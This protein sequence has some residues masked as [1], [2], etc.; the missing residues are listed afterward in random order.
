MSDSEAKHD[1]EKIRNAHKLLKEFT[2]ELKPVLR[3]Y[4]NRTLY[5]NVE[6]LEIREKPVAAEMKK[7]FVGGKGFDLKLLWDAVSGATRW[8]SPENEIF[9]ATGPICG[10]TNYPGS[11]KSLV[12]TISPMTGIPIDCNV[13]GYFGPYFKFS[14]FDALEIQGKAERDVLDLHRRQRGQGADHRSAAGGRGFAHR[15]P[16][17]STKCSPPTSATSSTSPWSRPAAAPSMPDRLP[18]LLLL[19][20]APQAA[21]LEA[22]GARRH[23]HRVPR[24]ED[25][26]PGG[27]VSPA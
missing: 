24:Q 18:Q 19:R 13:G 20:Q 27:P 26:G 23:R 15:R 21:A 17:N 12:T 16:N 22:G 9:I 25:Q 4:N 8:D 3:G 7:K 6:S 2:Y 1:I 14:G 11:G 10:N 5:I